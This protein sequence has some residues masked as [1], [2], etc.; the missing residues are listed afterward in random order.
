MESEQYTPEQSVG[1]RSNQK[2]N[3][4]ILNKNGTQYSKT[5][6]IQQKQL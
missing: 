1:Q 4:N 6:G 3:K 5:Y 2:G